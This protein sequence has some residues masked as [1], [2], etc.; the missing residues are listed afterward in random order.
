MTNEELKEL[1]KLN[2]LK[3]RE[4]RAL[5]RIANKEEPKN[6][7]QSLSEWWNKPIRGG[8]RYDN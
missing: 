6:V 7:L 5:E 2:D 1:R 3:Q 4:V 8:T